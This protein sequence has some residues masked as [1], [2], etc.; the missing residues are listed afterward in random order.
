MPRTEAPLHPRRLALQLAVSCQA[1]AQALELQGAE[2]IQRWTKMA[3]LHRHSG[4]DPNWRRRP[5][6]L[7][8]LRG[9]KRQPI[10]RQEINSGD[11][12]H[13]NLKVAA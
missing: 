6:V 5:S 1:I 10:A 8:Q 7:D 2:A 9:W 13:G 11:V 12:S 4:R 3:E